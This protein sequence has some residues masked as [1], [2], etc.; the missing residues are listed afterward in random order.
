L[1]RRGVSRRRAG[2]LDP[3][4]GAA[5]GRW[6][7]RQEYRSVWGDPT[8]ACGSFESSSSIAGDFDALD[9]PFQ[10]DP[11]AMA[12]W[13]GM[14]F[15]YDYFTQ[16]GQTDG[17]QDGVGAPCDPCD[18]NASDH[19]DSDGDGV[20]D[21]H[22]QCPSGPNADSDSDGVW[23]CV[24][25]CDADAPLPGDPDDEYGDADHDGRCNSTDNCLHVANPFQQN[26]NEIAELDEGEAILG[27]ACD[28]VPCPSVFLSTSID[29]S[30]PVKHYYCTEIPAPFCPLP[31]GTTAWEL[32][33]ALDGVTLEVRPLKGH[34]E[35]GAPTPPTLD[36]PTQAFFCQG[37]D[38]GIN[39]GF[40]P[41]CDQAM[42][43]LTDAYA[44]SAQC[45]FGCN[46]PE[47][48]NDPFHRMQI[49]GGD[50]NVPIATDYDHSFS[51]TA[52]TSACPRWSATPAG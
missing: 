52:W 50:P 34:H 46:D 43:D 28:P 39:G 8:T 47:T 4:P 32:C 18:A 37:S 5:G 25:P 38:G 36:V 15:A 1:G 14:H 20:D 35:T 7:V 3:R 23:D 9:A 48:A 12:V 27:D 44:T 45:A 2:R 13:N 33:G 6:A 10:S 16:F 40:D 17:D 51:D 41:I 26:C 22:D 21:C 30:N 42:F 29:T 24:D 11:E 31:S 19:V 49:L